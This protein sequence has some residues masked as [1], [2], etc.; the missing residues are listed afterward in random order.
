M[1]TH[2]PGFDWD[3]RVRVVPGINIFVHDSHA[4]PAASL[5][6]SVL[7]LVTVA[8]M[9]DGPAMK[10][11]ELLRYLAESAWYPTALLP[12][13]GMRWESI[14]ETS[15]RATLTEGARTASMD[16]RFGSDDPIETVWSASRP[17]SAGESAPWLC[18]LGGY[19]VSDGMRIPLDGRSRRA[20]PR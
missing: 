20:V 12:S 13:Q 9:S 14:D 8:E 18:W 4:L 16:F 1:T 2:P 7:G 10:R 3:A 17:R 5:R 19:A 11:G 15:A 6:A